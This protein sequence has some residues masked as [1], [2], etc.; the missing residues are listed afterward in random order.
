MALNLKA[1]TNVLRIRNGVRP[2]VF[3]VSMSSSTYQTDKIS[4]KS[5]ETVIPIMV[6]VYDLCMCYSL[7]CFK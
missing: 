6:G 7:I 3:R 2:C 1:P 4:S 5:T